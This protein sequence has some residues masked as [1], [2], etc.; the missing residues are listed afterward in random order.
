M[1]SRVDQ[2]Y[3]A[4]SDPLVSVIIPV[5]NDPDGVR[6]VLDCLAKQTLQKDQFEVIIGDDGSCPDLVPKVAGY[7]TFAHVAKGPPQTSYAARNRAVALSR[8]NVLAFCDADCLPEPEWLEQGLAALEDADVVAG[9]VRL[10]APVPPTVW[11]LLTID[12]FLDQRQNVKLSR[13]V[14]ANLLVRRSYFDNFGGFDASLPSGGDYDFVS[15]M[16]KRGAQL[17]YSPLA[18]VDHP[19][20][21]RARPFLQK[22]FRTNF[23]SGVRHARD[24]ERMDLLG[25]LVLVPVLGVMI[26]RRRALRPAFRLCQER[27]ET[28][29]VTLNL[30]D[31]VLAIAALYCIVSFVAGTGRVLG[32]LKGL[33]LTHSKEHL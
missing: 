6:L 16:A 25:V 32:W 8:G 28:S 33:R 19:T 4:I 7:E 1:E 20:M 21:D 9:E 5:R 29:N 11:S 22:I 15:R 17:K 27:L 23:W 13:G 3:L 30:R 26:A 12:L 18:V 24:R 14:T 10:Q 31:A 2:H